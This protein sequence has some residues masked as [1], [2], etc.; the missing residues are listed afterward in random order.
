VVHISRLFRDQTLINAFSFGELCKQQGVIIVTPQM[1]LNL[2]DRMHMRIY[3]MEAERAA[4]E[5]DIMRS[6]LFGGQ[7]L[8]AQQGYYPGGSIPPGYI[9]DTRKQIKLDGHFVNNPNYQKYI[10]YEPHAEVVRNLFRMARIPGI[11]IPQ[12]VRRCRD[13][14]LVLPQFPKDVAEVKANLVNFAKSHRN[15][16]GS[17]P[18]TVPRTRSILRNPAYIGW[19]IWEGNLVKTDNHPPIISE[20]DFWAVQEL[21]GDRP[22]YPKGV[23]LPLALSGLLYCGDHDVPRRMIYSHGSHK[24][25]PNYQC[26]DISIATHCTIKAEYLDGPIS[27][28][29]ISQCAYPELADEVLSRLTKEYEDTAARSASL[30][31]EYER[32]KREIEN[33][34]HNFINAK[35]SPERAARIEEQIQER[36]ARI[37][38]LSDIRNTEVGRL[39]EPHI[40]QDDV[41]LVKRFLSNLETGW[42]AQPSDLKN[43]FLRLVLDRI[44]V[45]HSPALIQVHLVWHT[46]LEQ[47][48]VIYRPYH[49]PHHRWTEHETA[50][51]QQNFEEMPRYQLQALLPNRTWRQIRSKAEKLGLKRE[52]KWEAGSRRSPYAPWE[53]EI[54][55]QLYRGDLSISEALAELKDRTE[56]SLRSRMKHLGL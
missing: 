5:L 48:L 42:E 30:Q 39:M 43:A 18:L 44:I 40:T 11:T 17:W 19:W 33:L 50:I 55:R 12:I 21:F 20:E 49:E 45:H 32:L 2:S 54:L 56:D 27:E 35:L 25:T 36:L 23:H 10:I 34:E 37:K 46:G 24:D 7:R 3:R 8:K 47:D 14:G 13:D 22:H 29:V 4:D 31:R 52:L 28:A 38:E 15:P 53:D 41:H 16:D 1:R 6:R 51:L 9:L 26:R